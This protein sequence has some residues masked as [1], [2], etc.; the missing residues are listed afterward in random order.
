MHD[1]RG[2]RRPPRGRARSLVGA[3]AAGGL[4][5]AACGSGSASPTHHSSASAPVTVSV[6]SW[7][8]QD[9]PMWQKIQTYMDRHGS[10]I[11]IKFRSVTATQYDSVL[12][13]SMDGG[14]G[15]NIFYA[16][17]GIGTLDYAAAKMIAPLNKVVNFSAVDP[18]TYSAV[19]YK[20][21]RYGVPFAIQTMEVF[22]NKQLFAKYGLHVPRTWSQLISVLQSLKSH[23]VIP[24]YVMGVQQWM[25]ALNLDEV[26]ATVMSDTFTKKLVQRQ[27]TYTSKP[28]VD[29]LA[30][31]QQL[32]QYFE[33]NWQGV[34]SAGDEQEV[35][36][37]LGKAGI[38]F[39]GIFDVPSIQKANPSIQLGA[40]LVP[41]ASPSQKAKVDW[42]TDGDIA[43]NSHISSPAVRKAAEKI[44]AFTATKRFG[45]YFT[46]IA[47]EISP[48]SGVKVPSKYPLSVQAYH[49]YQTDK[50][51]PIFGIRS[52]MDTPS[53]SASAVLKKSSSA[54][55][56]P[57]IFSAEQAAVVPLL[58]H[59]L[60]P[61]QA[62]AK[63]QA[64]ESWY[65][66]G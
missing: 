38:I 1:R 11:R 22:Y 51:N 41:P 17:A 52:P 10:N 56:T 30:Q 65:F 58:E 59:K 48:I 49:W 25:L 19:T 14:V 21:Q 44:V 47:G 53:P 43:M 61:S 16:R 20:G 46:N 57:G 60:S 66:K 27:A 37:A 54:A 4:L 12:Q 55:V 29:T 15:P 9:A 3:L 62:A 6:W 2:Q 40:F 31:F 5:L 35:A 32:S 34:G 39:D 23:G 33:P 42:Y 28:Y 45:Q 18:S 8:S 36:L 63:I 24:M 7:R 50:I 13:T 64:Q 26:G